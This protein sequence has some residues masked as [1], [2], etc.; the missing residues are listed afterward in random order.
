MPR[1]IFFNL[2]SIEE[3]LEAEALT[4][5]KGGEEKRVVDAYANKP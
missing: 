1:N 3:T 4:S 2:A 5:I